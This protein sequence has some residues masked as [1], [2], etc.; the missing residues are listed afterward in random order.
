MTGNAL[1]LLKTRRDRLAKD[2]ELRNWYSGDPSPETT[3]QMEAELRSLNQMIA[4]ASPK[5]KTIPDRLKQQIKAAEER[6]RELR[7]KARKY[8]E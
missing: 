2:V 7:A 5:P 3:R 1:T 4:R 6:L 8:R